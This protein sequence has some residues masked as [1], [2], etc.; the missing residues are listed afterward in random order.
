M[1]LG[2]VA[3]SPESSM[4]QISAKLDHL[5]T[6][7][8]DVQRNRGCLRFSDVR[9]ALLDVDH[10]LHNYTFCPCPEWHVAPCDVGYIKD[11]QFVHLCNVLEVSGLEVKYE[12]TLVM[13]CDPPSPIISERLSDGVI[14]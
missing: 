8:A 3:W 11:N 4:S 5:Y 14:R 1:L 12:D 6:K 10:L 7:L 9:E 13:K 2:A